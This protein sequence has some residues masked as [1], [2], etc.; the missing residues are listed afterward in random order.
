MSKAESDVEDVVVTLAPRT[1]GFSGAKLSQL[2]NEAKRIALKR[3]GYNK[4]ISP[5]VDDALEALRG[6]S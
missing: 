6:F 1:E 3:I 2:C 4:V 5:T